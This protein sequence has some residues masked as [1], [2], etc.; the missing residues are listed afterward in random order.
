VTHVDGTARVQTV[1]REANGKFF[2]LIEAFYGITGV[3]VIMNTSFNDAGEPIVETPEDSLICFMNTG[4]DYLVL[5]DYIVSKHAVDKDKLAK[6]MEE[7]RREAIEKRERA[8]IERFCPGYDA[9]EAKAFIEATNKM[10]EWHVRFGAKYETEKQVA[11]W[12]QGG[13]KIAIVGTID[14]TL[15]LGKHINRFG[16]LQVQGFVPF[17]TPQDRDGANGESVPYRIIDWPALD[18]LDVDAILISSHEFMFDIE[19]AIHQ[20]DI[21]KP[22]FK[23]YDDMS[24]SILDTLADMPVYP[25]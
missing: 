8:L 21:G 10:A 9:A 24:R 1:T 6:S 12:V 22:V 4:L 20:R 23:V 14:H 7:D 25:C 19:G 18:R 16:E 15:A 3:P 5:G 13:A 11:E 2:D 17:D